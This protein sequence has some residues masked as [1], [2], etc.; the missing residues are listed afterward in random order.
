MSENIC[1]AKNFLTEVIARVDFLIPIKELQE[2]L[3]KGIRSAALSNFPLAEPNTIIAEELQV[4]PP[5]ATPKK[6]AM[7]EWIFHDIERTKSLTI[8]SQSLFVRCT[9]YLTYE[10][11]KADFVAPLRE[12]YNQYPNTLVKRLGLRYINNIDIPSASGDPLDWGEYIN[13]NMLTI[14][15]LYPQKEY[16]SRA[17]HILE[18]NFD[19]HYLR[20]QYGMHNPDFPA[21]IRKR[22]F[23]IDLDAY[24]QGLISFAEINGGLDELHTKNQEI[25]ELSIRDPLRVILNG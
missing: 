8:T 18:F 5:K 16:I 15:N 12:I 24:Q 20:F 23:V 22:V 1:Y 25:F 13:P 4:T 9:K 3:P 2:N 10:D 17:F 21:K 19:N 7:T 14:F 11:L 6:I